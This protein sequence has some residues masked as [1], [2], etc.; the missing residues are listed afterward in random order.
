[1]S[2][3][4]KD[5]IEALILTV[6]EYEKQIADLEKENERLKIGIEHIMDFGTIDT[7]SRNQMNDLLKP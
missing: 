6:E 3:L 5:H 4:N 1:M 2:V 7:V